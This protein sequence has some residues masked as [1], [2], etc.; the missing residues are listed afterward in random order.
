[1][2]IS[3]HVEIKYKTI[4]YVSWLNVYTWCV[5]VFWRAVLDDLEELSSNPVD[6]E[7]CK[8]L[9]HIIIIVMPKT[10]PALNGTLPG[11][12]WIHARSI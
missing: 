7:M 5:C 4:K 3:V 6:G 11:L 2:A 10:D 9:T 1:M 8:H 12:R